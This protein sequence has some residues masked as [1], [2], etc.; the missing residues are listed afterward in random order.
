MS[1][2]LRDGR[3]ADPI[4]A[5]EDDVGGVLEEL[6]RHQR[7]NGGA[8]AALGPSPVEVAQRLEAADMSV[9]QSAFQATASALPFL[10]AQKR[11]DPGFVG[12]LVPVRQKSM[13]ME[14]AGAGTPWVG[15]SHLD[16]P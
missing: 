11:I 2:V 7:V 9:A 6:K 3:F 15:V 10:P 12:D 5:D 4:R 14:R 1:D 13:Q 8:F 16:R